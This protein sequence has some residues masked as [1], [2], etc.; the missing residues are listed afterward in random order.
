MER[1]A[2][3]FALTVILIT[4][5]IGIF[6]IGHSSA[7]VTKPKDCFLL[8]YHDC[9]KDWDFKPNEKTWSR[10]AVVFEYKSFTYTR[11]DIEPS[12]EDWKMGIWFRWEKSFFMHQLWASVLG[13]IPEPG[14]P[15]YGGS[16]SGTTG[17]GFM[18]KTTRTYEWPVCWS[19][20]PITKAFYNYCPNVGANA[21][22][23]VSGEE[24]EN[25]DEDQELAES[26]EQVENRLIEMRDQWFE[27]FD[28]ER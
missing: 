17:Q 9:F 3:I 27:N 16:L 26:D 8:L 21:A 25:E 4:L 18:T 15:V 6:D 22:S 24:D 20:K 19:I 13:P 12:S 10:S 11:K 1:M 5:V 14:L 7:A 28:I 2:R 23:A